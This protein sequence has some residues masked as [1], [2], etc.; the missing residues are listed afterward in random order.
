ME[1]TGPPHPPAATAGSARLE[2][3]RRSSSFR[4][5]VFVNAEPAV[6][7]APGKV[8]GL[9]GEWFAARGLTRPKAPLPSVPLRRAAFD[10]PPADDVRLTWMGHSTVLI[11]LEGCRLLCD[12]I[13][14]DRASPARFAGP[15]RFQPAP[16]PLGE[17]PDL[18]AVVVSHDHYDHL[19]KATVQAIAQQQPR[20]P[21][22]VPLGVGAHFE[23]FGIASDR[24][25]ELDL[26][27]EQAVAS[28]ALRLVA[29][30]TRHF[31]GRGVRDRD[32]TLWVSWALVGRRHR[33]FFGG[34][35]GYGKSFA[36][37][38]RRLGPFDVTLLEIGAHHPAWGTIH[39]GPENALV[40]HADLSGQLLLP[41]HW[42]AF[43][44][45]IHPWD[46]PIEKLFETASASGARV[47]LPRLGEQV[48]ASAP[49]GPTPWWRAAG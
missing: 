20:V 2:R 26:W 4:G 47:A 31:S 27:E 34:D 39:L 21:F 49:P 28:G 10:S 9:A 6:F 17:L 44:L 38:G 41:I 37:V 48:L 15:R 19:D 14:S 13:W 5:G 33:V 30:P 42:G 24:V 35:G 46:E 43:N 36:E 25:I 18:D 40:A 3:L 7:A 16:L 32:R 23:R 1:T 29:S 11:E 12:P 22:I 45:A 8:L